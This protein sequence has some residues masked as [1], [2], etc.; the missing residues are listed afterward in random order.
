MQIMEPVSPT[1]KLDLSLLAYDGKT[2]SKF[3]RK[4]S[5]STPIR[6]NKGCVPFSEEA[7]YGEAISLPCF[8]SSARQDVT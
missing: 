2:P 6:I 4:I 8:A 3:K 7:I 5:A 1:G